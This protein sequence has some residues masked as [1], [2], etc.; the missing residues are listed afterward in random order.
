M[1]KYIF[2]NTGKHL[3]MTKK[4]EPRVENA[5]KNYIAKFK[6]EINVIDVYLFGSYAKGNYHNDSDIDIAV[7]SDQFKGNCIEDRLLLM[8]LRRDIDLRIEPHP[9]RPEDFT[10]E[11][12]FV[13][14]IKE[15]GIRIQC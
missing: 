5:I 9:F 14:E 7:I 4:F 11:N 10:D 1:I 13:K 12:P 15:Y 2:K 8:R 3:G 6:K